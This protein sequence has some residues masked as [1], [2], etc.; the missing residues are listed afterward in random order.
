MSDSL[1]AYIM[2]ERNVALMNMGDMERGFTNAD[3]LVDFGRSSGVNE[4]VIQG[5]T[6]KALCFRRNAELDSAIVYYNEAL[7]IAVSDKNTEWEQALVEY[8]AIAYTESNR[9]EEGFKFSERALEIAKEMDDTA[10]ILQSV[11][12]LAGNLAKSNDFN[13]TLAELAPYRPLLKAAPPTFKVK[14]LTP[15]FHTYLKLDS[16]PQARATLRQME[17]A[18]AGFPDNHY[19]SVIVRLCRAKLYGAEGRYADE[20]A[21]YLA[22]DSI[23]TIGRQSED[24]FLE[25]AVCLSHL[26]RTDE[27]FALMRDA[28]AA[29]DSTRRSDVQKDL[30]DLAVKYDTLT[31]ELEIERL[32]HQRWIMIFGLLASL[33]VI[34]AIAVLFIHYRSKSRRRLERERREQYIRGLE[35][36]RGRIAR[37][38]HDDI[39]GQLIG[40]QWE[41]PGM[42]KDDAT[43]RILKIGQRI[44]TLSH[45]MMP[46]EFANRTF[47]QLL[48]DFAGNFNAHHADGR[49]ISLFDE[50]SFD[51][52]RLTDR[53]SYELYRIV[54]ESVNN[55][56][57]HSESGD[58]II[59]LDG[60]ERFSLKIENTCQ[61][62]APDS[63]TQHAGTATLKKRAEIIGAEVSAEYR[64][65]RF[66]LTILQK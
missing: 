13:R 52:D 62:P 36:E 39:A 51:W 43:E 15:L 63:P 54:Q 8:L 66:I 60:N 31:K 7:D 24:L 26:G 4:A 23:G 17:E 55:A 38:L 32:A 47:C 49:H 48:F 16:I 64:D 30:S 3:T 19:Q 33:T 12:T 22:V 42:T 40:L 25:K 57:K 56:M 37:E 35:E 21:T 50:G 1:R 58:I 5:L 46:P 61:T 27:A 28:Y 41:M 34:A 45:E 2:I 29:L 59:T 65:N 6:T 9:L 18:S 20:Y 14:I 11:G 44:R 10:A 53:Q